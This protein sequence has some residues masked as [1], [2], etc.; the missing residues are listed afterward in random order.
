VDVVIQL[1]RPTDYSPDE[2]AR[3][4]VHFE[5]YRNGSGGDDAKPIEAKLGKDA[6]GR[7]CWTWRS[8]EEGTL[9][10]VIAL[11]N[12]GL[13]TGE[14]ASELGIHKSRVSHHLRNAREMGKL[15]ERKS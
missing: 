15:A 12:D 2:G 13:K 6:E 4:E 9:D 14:I 3:V 1:K 11:A 8:V 7:T 10:R 5:K